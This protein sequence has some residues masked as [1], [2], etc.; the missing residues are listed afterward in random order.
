MRGL[1]A[2]IAALFVVFGLPT[3]AVAATGPTDLQVGISA[4]SSRVQAGNI[5]YFDTGAVNNG[6]ADATGVTITVQLP[7]GLTFVSALSDPQCSGSGQT[8]VC[9][10]GNMFNHSVTDAFRIATQTSTFG[11]YT[12]TAS[13]TADQSDTV[14]SNNSASATVLVYGPA[15]LGVTIQGPAQVDV[16][17]TNS[18]AMAVSNSGPDTTSTTSLDI[19]LPAQMTVAGWNSSQGSCQG[20]NSTT[21]ATVHCDLGIVPAGTTPEV[22]VQAYAYTEGSGSLA[23]KVASDRPDP[24]LSNNSASLATTVAPVADVSASGGPSVAPAKAN[25][26]DV[27]FTVVVY[28]GGPST[29]TSVIL[30][31]RWTDTVNKTQLTSFAVDRGTCSQSDDARLSCVIGTLAPGETAT[32]TVTVTA[33]GSGTVT[34][35]ATVSAAEKDPDVSNNT[36]VISATV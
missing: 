26:T 31:D 17:T 36:L 23:A 27:T 4:V 7:A 1:V 6:P 29:A 9:P 16:R 25:R 10:V 12:A 13:V 2:A 20:D 22:S 8:V 24:D 28:N 34:D 5:A 21:P 33:Q 19:S 30:S 14:P 11:T 18:Y 32:L 35:T 3:A 15:N